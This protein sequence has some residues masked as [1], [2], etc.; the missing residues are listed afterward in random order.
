MKK[1][2][3]SGKSVILSGPAAFQPCAG[4]GTRY[5]FLCSNWKY[6]QRPEGEKKGGD[7]QCAEGAGIRGVAPGEYLLFAWPSGA[8][9][10]YAEPEFARQYAAQ[11]KPVTITEG[12]KVTVNIDRPLVLQEP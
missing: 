7:S 11:G 4:P 6:S 8:Q 2:A 1:P 10:E 12:A 9:V 3:V 5:R